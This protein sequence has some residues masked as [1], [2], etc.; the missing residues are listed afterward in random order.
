LDPFPANGG[1]TTCDLLWMGVPLV[2]RQT[3]AFVGRMGSTFLLGCG[4]P[5][6]IASSD[7]AYVSIACSLATD[8]PA[9]NHIR[10]HLRSQ[11]E[12]S[13]A[14]QESSFANAFFGALGKAFDALPAGSINFHV[15][16][17]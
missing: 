3:D 16:A 4:H 15:K 7:D 12:R 2:T 14:M 8:I 10:Q 13:P 11:F 1:T 5:E 17:S 6:W 9:L